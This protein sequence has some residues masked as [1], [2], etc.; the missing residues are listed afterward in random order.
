MRINFYDDSNG[1]FHGCTLGVNIVHHLYGE[2]F[3]TNSHCT[4]TQAQ[5]TST[6]LYQGGSIVGTEVWDPPV[7]P[8]S[9]FP[10]NCN[11]DYCRFADIAVIEYNGTSHTL[12]HIADPVGDATGGVTLDGSPWMVDQEEDV[13]YDGQVVWMVGSTSGE[14]AGTVNKVCAN[15]N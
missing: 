8:E 10:G 9:Q 13:P 5:N 11:N 3:L 4:G 14:N 7:L 6:I 2:A 12:G 15:F 1:E